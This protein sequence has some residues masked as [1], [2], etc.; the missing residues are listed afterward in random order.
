M[1]GGKRKKK[2]GKKGKARNGHVENYANLV[3]NHTVVFK[4]VIS[5]LETL[6]FSR[7]GNFL[8][9]EVFHNFE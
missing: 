8:L 5:S 3:R 4:N 9:K 6:L 2:E 1:G 7:N